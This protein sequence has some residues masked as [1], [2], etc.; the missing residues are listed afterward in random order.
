M[1]ADPSSNSHKIEFLY[2]NGC[3]NSEPT[4]EN[5]KAALSEMN[6][7]VE[8]HQVDVDPTV[9]DQPFLG[10]PSIVANGIDLYTLTRPEA[11]EFAC[12]TFDIDGEK[13]GVL[14]TKFIRDRLQKVLSSGVDDIPE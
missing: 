2:F 4:L 10:S 11:F 6:I 13:T 12:R 7:D 8:P 5:L 9:F 1:K 3:P 14:P